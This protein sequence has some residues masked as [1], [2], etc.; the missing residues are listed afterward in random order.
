MKQETWLGNRALL[1]AS[2]ALLIISWGLRTCGYEWEK[3]FG[4]DDYDSGF[5]VQ[6]T[7]HGG[8]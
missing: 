8:S 7:A 3:T 4:G 5:S 6:Q 2:V 1:F